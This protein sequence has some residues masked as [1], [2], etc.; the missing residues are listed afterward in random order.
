[1]IT[2]ALQQ[3]GPAVVSTGVVSHRNTHRGNI[4]TSGTTCTT[5]GKDRSHLDMTDIGVYKDGTVGVVFMDNYSAFGDTS[6]STGAGEDESPFVHFARITSGPS[7]FGATAQPISA[8]PTTLSAVKD[9][10]GDATWPNVSGAPNLSSLDTKEIELHRD[11]TSVIVHMDIV[12]IS[13]AQRKADLAAFNQASPLEPAERIV[14]LARFSNSTQIYHLSF[15]TLADGTTRC[16]GGRLDANDRILNPT[17]GATFG[18][19]YNTDPGVHATCQIV[20]DDVVMRA[21]ISDFAGLSATN[22]LFSVTGF[23][24][25]GPT[26]ANNDGLHP[27]RT[28]DATPPL[29]T[30]S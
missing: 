11:S 13:L 25:A 17:S 10:T 29:D 7:L 3:G 24:M 27:M 30:S 8:I 15:E 5:T 26:E 19:A 16:Y 12:N 1:V 2:N 9:P 6:E 28:V 18:A 14:Y 22:K 21:P 4:C 20:G 23:T